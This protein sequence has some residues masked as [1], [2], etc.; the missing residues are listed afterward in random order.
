MAETCTSINEPRGF[1]PGKPAH[2]GHRLRRCPGAHPR[3]PRPTRA[4]AAGLDEIAHLTGMTQGIENCLDA[5]T[6]ALAADNQSGAVLEHARAL[7]L[8]NALPLAVA[9]R[10]EAASAPVAPASDQKS[11]ITG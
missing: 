8:M 11:G 4:S 10:R 5:G 9:R 6:Q 7:V 3:H 2:G 1:C